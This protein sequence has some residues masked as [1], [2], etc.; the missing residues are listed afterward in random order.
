MWYNVIPFFVP[1]DPNFYPTYPTRTKGL[2]SLIFRNYKCYVPRNVYLISKQ[3]VVPPIYRS[4][5]V[6]N[7]FLIMV[8]PV[9][10]KDEQ[11]IQQLVITPVPTI[12]H[13]TTNLPTYVLKGSIHQPL[14]GK[15]HGDSLR[16]S[17]P[18]RDS[19]RGSPPNPFLGTYEW[20]TPNP[21]MFI[22]PWY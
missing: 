1:L 21:S 11:T 12:I 10:S 13:V 8:Q 9:T 15:Q 22:P 19:P 16:R 5:Y 2:D 18:R 7:Q 4:H 3:Y 17:S 14:D 20:P 6:G